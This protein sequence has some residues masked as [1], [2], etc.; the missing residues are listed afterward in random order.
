MNKKLFSV[1]LLI[2]GTSLQSLAMESQKQLSN[3]EVSALAERYWIEFKPEQLA[4]QE[5]LAAQ[6]RLNRYNKQFA[7]EEAQKYAQN[8]Q[9][10]QLPIQEYDALVFLPKNS[11]S[12]NMCEQN[13]DNKNCIQLRNELYA[14]YKHFMQFRELHNIDEKIRSNNSD[15]NKLSSRFYSLSRLILTEKI[16]QSGNA[17]DENNNARKIEMMIDELFSK[18]PYERNNEINKIHQA[19]ENARYNEPQRPLNYKSKKLNQ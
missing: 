4:I 3:K 12:R 8:M 9:S 10:L 1:L 17:I 6:E 7:L 13:P 15:Q 19:F 14:Q 11:F 2:V 16:K 18:D 5:R